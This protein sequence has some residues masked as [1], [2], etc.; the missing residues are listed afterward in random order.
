MPI[1]LICTG[2][3]GHDF[4]P[5]EKEE[6]TTTAIVSRTTLPIPRARN[7]AEFDRHGRNADIVWVQEE[8]ADIG[9]LFSMLAR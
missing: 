2:K 7:R 8:P 9:T 3:I 4:K 5:N 6:D 1:V